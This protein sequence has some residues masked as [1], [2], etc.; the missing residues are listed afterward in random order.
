MRYDNA[1][2]LD[3]NQRLHFEGTSGYPHIATR[4]DQLFQRLQGMHNQMD[5]LK[6][7]N[8]EL[9]ENDFLRIQKPI[10]CKTQKH[11]RLSD[12]E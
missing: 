6:D 12:N 8:R 4:P 11:S 9:E 2:Q 1:S 3:E 5:V 10:V 7:K